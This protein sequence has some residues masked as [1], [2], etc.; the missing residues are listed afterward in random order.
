M[1]NCCVARS[2]DEIVADDRYRYL[3]EELR[4]YPL[5]SRGQGLLIPMLQL[6]QER[7]GYLP[8]EDLMAVA[9]LLQVPAAKVYGVATFYNQFR[10]A[11]VGRHII[12]VCCGTACHVKGSALLLDALQAELGIKAGET[13]RDGQ[14]S[15]EKVN[16][17][18]ACGIAPVIAVDEE[19]HGRMSAG[20]IPRML[21]LY[22]GPGGP[23][24]T[25]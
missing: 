12:K 15:L 14:F 24:G 11:P 18:G 22:D 21:K 2:I 20:Q 19:F 8:R 4:K 6:A 13:T 10:L 5:A 23:E 17:L 1:A 7:H 25:W 3:S 9:A 16:C